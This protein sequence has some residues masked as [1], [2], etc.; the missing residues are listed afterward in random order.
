MGWRK[1]NVLSSSWAAATA[2]AFKRVGSDS[3]QTCRPRGCHSQ[4]QATMN[5]NLS[6]QHSILVV[7]VYTAKMPLEQNDSLEDAMLCSE[8]QLLMHPL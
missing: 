4:R 1:L 6:Y 8:S 7:T 5:Q 2:E 3:A